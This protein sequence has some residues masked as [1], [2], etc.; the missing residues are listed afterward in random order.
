VF[1]ESEF[2]YKMF[3]RFILLDPV[4][5]VLI[6]RVA[7]IIMPHDVYCFHFSFMGVCFL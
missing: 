1:M 6:M 2:D 7:H 5:S 3:L 4:Q